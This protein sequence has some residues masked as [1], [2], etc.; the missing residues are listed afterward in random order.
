VFLTGPTW[1]RRREELE[2]ATREATDVIRANQAIANDERF[3][4]A[5]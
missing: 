4:A 5:A 2:K 1:F 3:L